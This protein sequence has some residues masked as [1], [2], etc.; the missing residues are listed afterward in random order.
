MSS[1]RSSRASARARSATEPGSPGR[2]AQA[3]AADDKAPAASPTRKR[4][5]AC[6]SA[7]SCSAAALAATER[8]PAP[9]PGDRMP[10]DVGGEARRFSIG[11]LHGSVGT[12]ACGAG[13][14][15]SALLI[16]TE[17]TWA[18]SLEEAAAHMSVPMR[19][20]V[21]PHDRQ[22][23]TRKDLHRQPSSPGSE[24]TISTS[25]GPQFGVRGPV[26]RPSETTDVATP[27]G[28]RESSS[29]G[30]LPGSCQAG[31]QETAGM[32]GKGTL[33]WPG[34]RQSRACSTVKEY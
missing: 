26:R 4:A 33:P 29:V 32:T 24:S 7:L 3:R 5:A 15:V 23:T 31:S 21:A 9:T 20:R 19:R 30:R 12:Q 16:I 28:L 13:L 6:A 1:C 17:A 14:R 8:K 18:R 10:A 34:R 27:G 11:V 22:R 2:R 25:T